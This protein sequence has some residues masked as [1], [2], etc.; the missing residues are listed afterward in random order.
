[1]FANLSVCGARISYG[2]TWERLHS[3]AILTLMAN[4]STLEAP[5]DEALTG[6]GEPRPHYAELLAAVQNGGPGDLADRLDRAIAEAGLVFSRS[7]FRV[8][9]LPRLLQASEWELIERAATQRANA[10]NRFCADAYGERAIV[11]AGIVP[12]RVITGAELYEPGMEGVPVAP[13]GWATVVGLDLVRGPGGEFL[14]LED[15]ARSP[16]GTS[17]AWSARRAIGALGLPGS[18]QG[19]PG[20]AFDAL[21]EALRAAA[22][23]GAGDPNIAL[24]S[25]GPGGAAFFEHDLI[26]RHL[27]IPIVTER[28]LAKSGGRLHARIGGVRQEIDILYR[29]IDGERLTKSGGRSTRLGNLL[30]EP[31]REGTL[32]IANAFGSGVADDKLTHAYLD[33]AIRF[34]LK[35][36]PVIASVPTFD[37]GAPEQLAEALERLPELVVKPRSGLGG[38]GVMIGPLATPE[39]LEKARG[40]IAAGPEAFVAQETISISTHPSASGDEMQPRRVDLRPFAMCAGDEV[41]VPR[42]ALTRF[43]PQAGEMIVNSSRGGGAKDTWVLA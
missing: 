24:F 38:T 41:R 27:D 23:A 14:V 43:A 9:P 26:A 32:A 20:E 17:F 30:L 11:A 40:E 28:D 6:S 21:G 34:Y 12:E 16:S 37:L 35:E 29:R 15:N 1:L 36:D 3:R 39:E 2:D 18:P 42:A 5:Y 19:G 7:R 4:A 25:E 33:D 31:L 10:L 13:G 22:P 8:D